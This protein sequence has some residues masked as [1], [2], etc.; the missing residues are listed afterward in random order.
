[1]RQPPVISFFTRG[2][3]PLA[4]EGN[5]IVGLNDSLIEEGGA[6]VA[7]SFFN[8]FVVDPRFVRRRVNGL[9]RR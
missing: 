3:Q 4:R 6:V 9:A 2:D 8:D 7:L 5:A 1:M